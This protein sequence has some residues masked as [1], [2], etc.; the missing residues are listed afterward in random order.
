MGDKSKFE[1]CTALTPSPEKCN[2]I[3]DNCNGT[4]DEGD[5]NAMCMSEGPIPPHGSYVCSEAGKC[6]LGP[7]ETGWAAY[8][9]GPVKDGCACPVEAG[10]LNNTCANATDA[11]MVTDTAGSAIALTG[12][13]SADDDVDVWTFNTVDNDELTTNSY[14]VS[15]NFTAPMPND[16]FVIDVIRGDTCID[17]P[18]GSTTNVTSYTWCVDGRGEDGLSGEVPCANDGSQPVHCN[19]NTKRYFVFVRRKPGVTGTCTGYN[20]AV[21][22]FGGAACDFTQKC[23]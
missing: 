19:N 1:G 12:T 8:P 3:D 20:V 14:H 9:K 17:T 13:L 11:G 22:A 18:T 23:E 6:D 7:C 4:T 5:A 10:E 2:A 15:I 16:E 21:T